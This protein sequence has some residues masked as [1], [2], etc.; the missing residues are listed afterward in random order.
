MSNASFDASH[1]P[2]TDLQARLVSSRTLSFP[3]C[4]APPDLLTFPGVYMCGSHVL[5][6]LLSSCN[7]KMTRN[8]RCRM[9]NAHVQAGGVGNNQVHVVEQI[10]R[11]ALCSTARN[12]SSVIHGLG[13]RT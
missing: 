9:S 5:V 8:T 11:L 13:R 10:L 1:V 6:L 7:T 4:Y 3:Q 2:S 12:G